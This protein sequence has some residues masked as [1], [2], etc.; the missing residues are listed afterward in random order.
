MSLVYVNTKT[1]EAMLEEIQS[2]IEYAD[3]TSERTNMEVYAHDRYDRGKK[4]IWMNAW[5][6]RGYPYVSGRMFHKLYVRKWLCRNVYRLLTGIYRRFKKEV[7]GGRVR[8]R[9][10]K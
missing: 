6:G 5:R 2:E 9:A 7:S 10:K 8:L 3:V 1:G 4:K